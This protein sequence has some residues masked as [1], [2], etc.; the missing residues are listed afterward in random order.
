MIE[1][2]TL[3]KTLNA[4]E[5]GMTNTND[6]YILIPQNIDAS[7]IFA[8]NGVYTVRDYLSGQDFDFRYESGREQRVY[9]LG[10][11]CRENNVQCGDIISLEKRNINGETRYFIKAQRKRQIVFLQ[12]HKEG[13]LIIR[14][15]IGDRIFDKEFEFFIMGKIH[16]ISINYIGHI[17]K[18]KDSPDELPFYSVKLENNDNIQTIIKDPYVELDFRNSTIKVPDEVKFDIIRQ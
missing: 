15:D 5:A 8:S 1:I 7:L 17:R 9:K 10:L 18:R 11:Y 4:T 2:V 3:T 13:Y 14:N 12:K 16:M 6:S